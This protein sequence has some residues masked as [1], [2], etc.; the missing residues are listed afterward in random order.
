M[1]WRP[2]SAASLPRTSSVIAVGEVRVG[3]V[4]QV[5]E[6][7]HREP[8]GAAR[9]RRRVRARGA[10]RTARQP[11]QA[12]RQQRRVTSSAGRPRQRG[13]PRRPGRAS[14]RAAAAAVAA[15]VAAGAAP[16]RTRPRAPNRS[17]GTGASAL[18]DRLRPPPP[19]RWAAP[20]ARSARG[21]VSRLAM[22]ACAVGAGERRLARQHLVEHRSRASRCRSARRAPGRPRPAPGS[23]RPACRPRARSRS[24]ARRRRRPSARAMPKSATSVLPSRGEQDVLGLDVA[25]DH[26]VLVGVLERRRPPRARSG[27]RPPPGAAARAGAG[28]AGVSPSTNGMVNQSRPRR[29]RR[30][31]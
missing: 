25:V 28:R 30:E 9:R 3:R 19:A 14:R 18:P 16:A 31:S 21:S 4:A 6:R 2:G 11:E 17:A 29:P 26:A 27:A 1:T 8:L 15:P 12:E 5:L 24:A 7:Q 10:R 23:C 13:R 20:R 22:I